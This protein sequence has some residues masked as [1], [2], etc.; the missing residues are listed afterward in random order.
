MR[1]TSRLCRLVLRVEPDL[2][3][4]LNEIAAQLFAETR[5]EFSHAAIVRG[6]IAI[7][8]ASLTGK[9]SIAS[10]FANVRIPRGRKRGRKHDDRERDRDP[11]L[12]L[13]F[14]NEHDEDE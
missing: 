1:R 14:K 11:D 6:L 3:D 10:D 4:A 13:E 9:A 12:D 8:R 5:L 2:P 7:G